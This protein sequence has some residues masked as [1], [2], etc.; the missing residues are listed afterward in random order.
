MSTWHYFKDSEVMGLDRELV[1][2][3]DLA[4]DKAG[5]PFLITSGLRTPERNSML[6]GAVSD[7]A[8]LKGLA[9]DL[10]L[11]GSD[12]IL[13]RILYGLYIAGFDR[14]GQYFS[15]EGKTLI[16]HHLHVDIDKTKPSQVTFSL[17]EQN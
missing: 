16:P 6:T 5:V 15:V 11:S 2:M 3:L 1:S 12:H 10:A 4:R 8:H 7:S 17:L 14:I 13:N 9:V